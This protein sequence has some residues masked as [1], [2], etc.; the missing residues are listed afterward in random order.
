[1]ARAIP[2]LPRLEFYRSCVEKNLPLLLG[3]ALALVLA[4]GAYGFTT[5]NTVANTRAG[6]GEAG[7][8]GFVVSNVHYDILAPASS[9][10]PF[11]VTGVTFDLNGPAENVYASLENDA[12]S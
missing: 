5:M 11:Y 8:S 3:T 12:H 4:T 2:S 1:M 10:D 6:E 9:Q 7:V